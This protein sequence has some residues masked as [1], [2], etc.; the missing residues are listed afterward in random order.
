MIQAVTLAG[1]AARG[2]R[3]SRA[4]PTTTSSSATSCCTTRPD[5]RK[6]R[7]VAFEG[8]GVAGV[9]YCGRQIVIAAEPGAA[10]RSA[11][12]PRHRG[13]RMIIGPRGTVRDFWEIVRY[14]TAARGWCATVSS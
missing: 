6:Q 8:D 7:S 9:V 5:A 10:P 13:A 14:W 2:A 1:D 11:S 12:T 4:R 3:V